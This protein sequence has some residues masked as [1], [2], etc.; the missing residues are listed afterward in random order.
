[1]AS[2]DAT[3]API[4][5]DSSTTRDAWLRIES[6]FA[7]KSQSRIYGLQD[8]LTKLVKGEKSISQ[9]FAEVQSIVNELVTAESPINES[10]LVIKILS[11]VGLDY[12]D[13]TATIRATYTPISLEKLFDKLTGHESFIRLRQEPVI[14]TAQYTRQQ[15]SWTRQRPF[16]TSN[17]R[18]PPFLSNQNGPRPNWYSSPRPQYIRPPFSRPNGPRFVQPAPWRSPQFSNYRP[19]I[20]CQLCESLRKL[21]PSSLL[22]CFYFPIRPPLRPYSS[23]RSPHLQIPASTDIGNPSQICSKIHIQ[24]S[25]FPVIFSSMKISSHRIRRLVKAPLRALNRVCDF[26]V[27]SITSCAD[28]MQYN[29]AITPLP[30]SYQPVRSA[31][32]D[33]T[34]LIQ[35]SLA[36]R[37]RAT[38]PV[39]KSR[40][41]AIGRIDEDKPCY[42]EDNDV[43]GSD[44]LFPK[45][46][47][48]SGG[49]KT[50]PN[51]FL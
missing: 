37:T 41:M 34:E 40:S 44:L 9:Y 20:Q 50:R 27:R 23:H 19:R 42:F 5:V 28:H 12:N 39:R 2:V 7:N 51:L 16:Q 38:P 17:T 29:T 10:V 32:E 6:Q 1:M 4:V 3:I 13:V 14:M 30:A 33:L 49:G 45:S 21:Q 35:V 46:R 36:A 22:P 31:D 24:I 26:Y 25:P 48:C 43:V 11:G 8:S 18:R 47:S 15:Q